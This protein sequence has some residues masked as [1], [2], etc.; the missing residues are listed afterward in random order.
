MNFEERQTFI[1]NT[2]N[3]VQDIILKYP[4]YLKINGELVS[5]EAVF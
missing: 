2:T 1:Q 3:N 4:D 5:S